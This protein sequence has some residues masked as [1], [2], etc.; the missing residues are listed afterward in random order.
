MLWTNTIMKKHRMIVNPTIRDKA[1][2]VLCKLKN[3]VI[4]REIGIMMTNVKMNQAID[5][6]LQVVSLQ[7]TLI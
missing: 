4:T 7:A 5:L 1:N 2:T 6:Y 3:K